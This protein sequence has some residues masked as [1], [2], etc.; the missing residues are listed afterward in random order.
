MAT[1]NQLNSP[2]P[3]AVAKGGTGVTSV[4]IAPSASA[5]AGWDANEN[6]S[7]NNH[8]EGFLSTV[9]SASTITLTVASPYQQ[10]ITGSTAQTF[11]MPVAS[12]LVEGMGWYI[13]NQSSAVT[14]VQSSGGNTII[15]MAANTTAVVTCILNSGTSAASWFAEYEQSS[16]VL[17]LSLANG[18]TNAAL[19]A[20]NGGIFY[21]TASAGA[22]LA[23]T[24]TANQILM[25]GASTT[26]AWSTNTYPAT[27]A[28]GDIHYASAANI[29]SGLA[30]GTT[31]Q[32]LT[33][34]SGLPSWAAASSGVAS[35][36]MQVFSA[37][38]TYTPTSGMLYCIIE[39]V[40][41][42]GGGGGAASALSPSSGQGGGGG[43]GSYSRIVS[44][45]ATIGA[46]QTVT[47]GTGGS[48]ASAGNNAG[49]N[50][51]DTSVGSICIGKGGTGGGGAAQ[52][53]SGTG[54]AGG[55]AGTGTV[56]IVGNAGMPGASNNVNNAG[57][58]ALPGGLG[59][60]SFFGGQGV[61]IRAQGAGTA[62]TTGSGGNGG[63]S[64]NGGA[65]VGGGAGGAGYVIITE[66]I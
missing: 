40:G 5:W 12:T 56:T 62:G 35:V 10:F 64:Y 16:L 25:S 49:G 57:N 45:A 31:G 27:D 33:V 20:S 34:V 7:A 23:G 4:T 53:A 30:I 18:G 61:A 46:S 63:A 51:G 60:A 24:S 41:A 54:G 50:G 38:G 11:V 17:P 66:Y 37:S 15:A 28:K 26:P 43:S 8:I 59:G 29:I 6:L 22:I 39:C 1:Q 36:A 2:E 55:V 21:S 19:T 58:C 44:S 48:A 9:S 3:F 47:I 14:T 13:V 52:D 42:G 32:V 65:A